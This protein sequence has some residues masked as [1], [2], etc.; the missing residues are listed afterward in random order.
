[1]TEPLVR[2]IDHVFVPVADPHPLHALFT[3]TL[4]LPAAWPVMRR[5]TFTSGAVCLGNANM[6][7]IQADPAVPFL[8]TVEPLLVRGI[9]FEPAIGDAWD[10]AL[11]ERDLPFVGPTSAEGESIHGGRRLLYTNTMVPG[12][13]DDATATFLCHYHSEEAV[14]GEAA[15]AALRDAAGGVIGV[16]GVAEVT[17]GLRPGVG[18]H[19]M[20]ERFL[21]PVSADDHG[22]YRFDSGPALRIKESPIDGVAGVWLEVGSLAAARDALRARKLLGPMRASGIGL[23]YARTGGLDVWLTEP[24]R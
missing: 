4:G 9:A 15:E 10:E 17:V 13:V 2:K 3:E 21:A 20:W 23:N 12:L 24:R 8:T 5:G 22:A 11:T 18:A 1:M 19:A 6:E 16:R 7:F 14:R